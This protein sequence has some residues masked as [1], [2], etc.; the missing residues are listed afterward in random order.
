MDLRSLS[1]S[2]G[3]ELFARYAHAPNALG[4]CGPSSGVRGSE[5][6]VRAAARRFSGAWPYLQVLARLVGID[7][8]LD[9]RLVEA[10]WLG[11]DLGVDRARFGAE[12]LAVIGPQAG[13]YWTHLTPELL[14]DGA[15]DHGFHVFGV[16]PW[17]R[18]LGSG[19]EPLR[20]LDSCRIGWGVVVSRDGDE[21]EVSSQRL[22]WDGAKLDLEPTVRRIV[23]DAEPGET[24]ALHWDQLCDRLT[25][26]QARVLESSTRRELAAT[27]ARMAA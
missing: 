10:Y 3:V 7:D 23:G 6:E 25:A 8:P 21:I 5:V 26:E 13:H 4:Y 18:L 14:A 2:A 24:V 11:R 16:Y 19:P 1:P 22:T 27:S 12:L 9:E 15:P 20:V 17:S